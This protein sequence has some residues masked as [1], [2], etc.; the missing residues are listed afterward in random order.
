MSICYAIIL[1]KKHQ[2]T[3]EEERRE[4]HGLRS[5]EAGYY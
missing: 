4:Q 2:K 5:A 1:A 3:K